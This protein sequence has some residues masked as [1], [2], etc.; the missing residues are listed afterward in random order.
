MDTTVYSDADI[1]GQKLA[2]DEFA[3][4]QVFIHDNCGIKLPITKK[5]MVEGR[6]R[7]RLKT[8]GLGSYTEYLSMVFSDSNPAGDDEKLRLIDA[9]TTNKTDFFREPNHFTYLTEKLLPAFADEGAGTKRC[10]NVWSSACSTGEEPYTLAMV[11]AEFFGTDGNFRIYASDIN[12]TVLEKAVNGIYRIDKAAA[13]PADFKKKYLMR[14]KT[15]NTIVR[16]RPELREKVSFFRLNLMDDFYR[17]PVQ[18]D[19]SFCRNVIIYFDQPT[20]ESI[21]NRICRCTAEGGYVFLG[22]SES[23]HGMNIAARPT[24]PTI[25]RRI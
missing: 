10:L 12:C 17:L 5:N 23:V 7:K 15:D 25:L 24:A 6:L 22:H 8:L 21:I 1:Y 2:P 4:I 11:L 19:V 13:I 3:R 9:I 20:Q 14:S 18:M 16:I